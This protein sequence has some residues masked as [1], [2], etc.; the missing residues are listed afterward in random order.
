MPRPTLAFVIVALAFALTACSG[1]SAAGTTGT[2][3]PSSAPAGE[4]VSIVAK[5]IA[6][7][8]TEVTVK[9]GTAFD[10]AFDNQDDAPHDIAISDASGIKV[11]AGDV[12]SH[13]KVTYAVPA[14]TAGTYVFICEIHPNMT[15]TITVQ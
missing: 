11:F 13:Q 5:D 6:F 8:T 12:V 14:L 2:P 9:A 1:A 4:T 10:I 3:D 15:G 7:Q